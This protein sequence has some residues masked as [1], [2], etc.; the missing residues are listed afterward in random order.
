[1]LRHVFGH[2]FRHVHIDELKV[3]SALETAMKP[4]MSSACCAATQ[5][6]VTKAVKA[7]ATTEQA[8]NTARAAATAFEVRF[9]AEPYQSS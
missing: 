3:A 5:A 1:M 4:D 2:V 6:A 8:I 9:G 7:G